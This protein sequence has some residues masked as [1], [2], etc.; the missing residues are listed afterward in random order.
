MESDRR[1]YLVGSRAGVT[2]VVRGCQSHLRLV[3]SAPPPRREK[4]SLSRPFGQ[5][6]LQV[7]SDAAVLAIALIVGLRPSA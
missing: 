2:L 7:A 5:R 4:R 6:I 3:H 1:L